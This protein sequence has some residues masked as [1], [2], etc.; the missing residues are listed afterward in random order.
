MENILNETEAYMAGLVKIDC[1]IKI[2]YNK[3]FNIKTNKIT[4]FN[5]YPNQEEIPK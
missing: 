5:I 4:E 1:E 3:H 2:L